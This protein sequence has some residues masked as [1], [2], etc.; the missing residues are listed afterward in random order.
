MCIKKSVK[1]FIHEKGYRNNSLSKN[2]KKSN[3]KKSKIRARVEHICDYIQKRMCSRQEA[4][5]REEY[6]AGHVCE[7]D[8]G[9][10][11]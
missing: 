9:E 2:Q 8:R 3:K 7:F 4:F 5:I 11:N 10:S 6:A 1:S